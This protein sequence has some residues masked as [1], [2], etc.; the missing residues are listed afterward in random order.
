VYTVHSIG[1]QSLSSSVVNNSGASGTLQPRQIAIE[2]FITHNGDFDFFRVNGKFYDVEIIQLWLENVLHVPIPTTVD[3]AAVAGVID[4]LRSQG[5]FALSIRYALCLTVTG[6]KVESDPLQLR[7][8]PTMEEYEEIANIFETQL[9]NQVS[10]HSCTLEDISFDMDKRKQFASMTTHSL[11]GAVED[12]LAAGF[13][14]ESSQL[15][16][17]AMSKLSKVISSDVDDIE[18]SK[19]VNATIDAFFDND[20]LHSTRL[21]LQNAK[22]SFGL[23]VASSLDAHRQICL[24]ARGQTMSV[25]FYPRKGL[26]CYGSEQAAVKAGLNYEIPGEDSSAILRLSAKVIKAKNN[27]ADNAVRLDMDDLGGEIC[28]LDWGYGD[29]PAVSPPN[30][31]LVVE[32]MM[33]DRVNVV[34]MQESHMWKPLSKRLTLL[35]GNEFIKPLLDDCLDPVLKD[36]Q[37]IPR[38]CKQIQDDW[39]EVGLNRMTAWN[40]ASCIRA[41]MKAYVNGEIERHGA[42]VDILVTGCEV[43]LWVAEQFV[44]DLQKSF[45]KLFIRAVSSNK[46]LGLFGHE[47]VMPCIGFPYSQKAMDMKDPIVIIVSHSGGTFGP[48]ACSNLLQSFSSSIF[49]VTSEWDTQIGKQLR[50]MYND[51]LLSSRIFSTEVGVRP[52]EPCSVSVVATHQLLTNVFGHI[53]ITI[54]SDPHFSRVAGAVI[55]ERDLQILERCNQSCLR[56]LEEIVG[57]DCIG[58]EVHE[59]RTITEQELRSAGDLWANHILENA[60]VSRTKSFVIMRLLQS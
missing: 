30:R 57:V 55:T 26:I 7:S 35:E 17:L 60:K 40:L 28:L 38:I 45:P 25:A 13:V 19:F 34:L 1:S 39:H 16:Y 53:C 59:L 22:G 24:A 51:D 8:Y 12:A 32:K 10:H 42:T 3:S 9:K 54:I 47:L 21:F 52:A 5:S 2:N 4:L 56:T 31:H 23:M 20:L 6:S 43:S 48:L 49:A 14:G 44:S 27:E 11:R 36:I 29:Q 37:D 58:N 18:L 50:S 41:R 15:H 33:N 46:L